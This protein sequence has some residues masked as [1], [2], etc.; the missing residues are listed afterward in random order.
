[1]FINL[2]ITNQF[3]RLSWDRINKVADFGSLLH[4]S[5]A[6]KA[7]S[8]RVSTVMFP[9]QTLHFLLTLGYILTSLLLLAFIIIII[10]LITR[11][12]RAKGLDPSSSFWLSEIPSEFLN[13]NSFFF[14][15]FQN[16]TLGHPWGEWKLPEHTNTR[17]IIFTLHVCNTMCQFDSSSRSRSSSDEFEMDV[18]EV[19]VCN[20]E[21]ERQF[22]ESQSFGMRCLQLSIGVHIWK[23]WRGI[24]LCF[25][26]QEQPAKRKGPCE[27]SAKSHWSWQR[28]AHT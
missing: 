20:W 26:L 12:Q 4:Q 3:V 5:D 27:Q 17:I 21:E 6:A 10:I 16:L 22:G 11:R 28:Y 15:Y 9:D 14:I 2:R 24:S 23:A 19:N 25:S 13:F 1:M 18:T 8:P 7:E